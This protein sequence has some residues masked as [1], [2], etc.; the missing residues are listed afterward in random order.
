MTEF[1]F[2]DS[3]RR[4]FGSL[5]DND[6]EG[7]GD[8]C[9]VYPV[10]GGESLLF[11]SDMLNENVHFLR[12]AASAAEIGAKSLSVNVS[13]IAAMGGR[14]IATMLSLGLTEDAVGEWAEEFMRGYRDAS[15]RCGAMLIGGDT[16][17]S[18]SG[19]TISVTAIGR[20]ADGNIKR[21]SDA[22]VGDIVFVNGMLGASAAG[23]K[24]ILSGHTDTANARVHRNP[25]PQ[26]EQGLWLG[27]QPC[28]H[29]MM[30]ISDGVA[31]DLL[32]IMKASGVGASVDTERIPTEVSVEE[33]VCGGEDYKLLFTADPLSA[34][35]LERRYRE[36]FGEDIYRIGRITGPD[37]SGIVWL[38]NGREVSPD[39]HGFSHF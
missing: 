37:R 10:G 13:D 30:D 3:I 31:S 28:V 22:S 15:E 32:H 39:W 2:I 4:A 34:A 7:I 24:D 17:I 20:C 21:R 9:A 27:G 8:D 11:T 25:V 19:I 18:E 35:D 36:R 16:T 38:D 23:L 14:P 29:A 26:T 5:P 12:S 1:G 33:A 6:F